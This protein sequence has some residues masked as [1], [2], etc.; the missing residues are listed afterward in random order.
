MDL[1]KYIMSR[2]DI[3]C[4]KKKLKVKLKCF[5]LFIMLIW[6]TWFLS[7]TFPNI[8]PTIISF[9]ILLGS[10]DY[11]I[12]AV[13]AGFRTPRTSSPRSLLLFVRYVYAC[14]HWLCLLWRAN[15]PS[16][17]S[18][19]AGSLLLSLQLPC[20]CRNPPLTAGLQ[21]LLSDCTRLRE[22]PTDHHP[23]YA[24]FYFSTDEKNILFLPITYNYCSWS[25]WNTCYLNK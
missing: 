21:V 16:V 25:L 5:I 24:H 9:I 18:H 12:C 7:Y 17:G 3:M 13:G 15:L 14:N 23:H 19:G 20:S 1:C 2:T 4:K 22:I 11:E 10:T 6:N 8:C